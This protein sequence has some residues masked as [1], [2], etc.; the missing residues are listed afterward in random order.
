MLWGRAVLCAVALWGRAVRTVLWVAGD[1]DW[2]AVLGSAGGGG[3]SFADD[4]SAVEVALGGAVLGASFADDSSA[5]EVALGG[6]VLG[7]S[8]SS[9]SVGCASS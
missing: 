3:A 7:A 5:V 1:S 9:S 6:V 2:G 8:S 4:S